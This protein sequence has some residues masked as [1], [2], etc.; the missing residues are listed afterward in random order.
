M[1]RTTDFLDSTRLVLAPALAGLAFS[2]GFALRDVAQD[3]NVAAMAAFSVA[4]ACGAV[5]AVLCVI[6]LR[7]DPPPLALAALRAVRRGRR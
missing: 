4:V 2:G 1:L 5:G 3:G 6:D 7:R